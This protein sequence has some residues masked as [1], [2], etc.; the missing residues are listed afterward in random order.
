[1]INNSYLLGLFGMPPD[2]AFNNGLSA[3]GVTARKSQPTPPW[4]SA[5]TNPEPDAVVRAALAGRRLINEGAGRLDLPGASADYRK[6]FA[7]YQ[8]LTALTALADRA[9]QRGVAVSEQTLIGRRFAAGL[10]EISGYLQ[11]AEFRDVRMVQGVSTVTAK[12]T[13]A[14]ARDSTRLVTRPVHEGSLTASVAAF[15][16]EVV[17]GVTVGGPSGDKTLSIDLSDMGED[18]RTLD[19]VIAHINGKLAD[20][21]VTTRLGREQVNNGPRTMKIGDKT[22]TLPPREDQWALA[23]QGVSFETVRFTA[24]LTSSAVYVVQAA[25]GAG[26]HELLKFQSDDG[27]T[28][29]PVPGAG[30]THWVAGRVSQTALPE[31][32]ETV[33]ASATAADGSLW[34]VADIAPGPGNQ[35]IKGES[36]VALMKYDSS[37][38]LVATRMLGAS[39]AASGYAIAIAADGR[40]AVAGSV[41]GALEPGKT[42]ADADVADSFVTVFDAAGEELWTQRR[43]AR[44][45]DEATAVS[46]GADG[47]VYVAGRSKSAMP[48]ASGLGG[49]DGY[50]QGF[51]ATQAHSLAP[52]TAVALSTSQFG[53]AGDDSVKAMTVEGSS[54]YTAGVESGRVVVRHYTLDPGGA[55]SLAGVRDLGLASGDVTGIAVADGRVLLTGATRNPALD[56]ATVNTAHSGGADAYVAVLSSDL[57]ANAAD[58][59]T[60]YGGAGDDSVSDAKV[61]EGKVWITGLAD[62]PA[63]AGK[64]DPRNGYLTRLDPLTGAI[65]WTRTW[66]GDGQQAAPLSLAVA[67]DG[68]SVLD[69]LGLPQ[70]LVATGDSK[71]LTT[72]TAL[73]SGDRFYISPAAGGRARA[74]TIDARDTLQTLARK[75]EQA[76]LGQLKVTVL[77]DGMKAGEE[78][79]LAGGR[80][81]RL[82]IT[83]RDGRDGAILTAGETGRDALA[84]LG[85]S[86]GFIGRKPGAGAIKTFALD[87]PPSLSVVGPEVIKATTERL[88][89]AMKVVR[90]AYRALAPESSKPVV[91]GEVPAYLKA[92]IANYQA[93]LDRLTG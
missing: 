81:Q 48:G 40:V 44:A 23:V 75:I 7:L 49:W 45:A 28:P 69:R 14:V 59:L 68:A 56:I 17:F 55:P 31:G 77:T 26:G 36:D 32:V 87:L 15:E 76:S 5:A 30:Q 71:A 13:A 4:S 73:R 91:K 18:V 50:V 19:N 64:D 86:P 8:G 46:F 34:V 52:F 93:A 57:S 78:S 66:S 63:G 88:R 21:G 39:S 35:P 12:T 67:S 37:G 90:D 11:S 61:H 29:E 58:R 3:T 38:R 2:T 24:P 89:A 10:S 47:Q 60:Y 22:I 16:G 27:A 70:G 82:S 65:E 25:G 51:T 33:R 20:A 92:Q 62:R 53:T 72:V 84:G 74:V 43:G 54:L 42:V 85:L 41:T 6:L 80:L 79:A 1:M 9:G 83:Q